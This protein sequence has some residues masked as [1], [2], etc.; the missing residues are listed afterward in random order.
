MLSVVQKLLLLLPPDTFLSLLP[1]IP[2]S[3]KE[4]VSFFSAIKLYKK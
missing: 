3:L 4:N 2:S 1:S